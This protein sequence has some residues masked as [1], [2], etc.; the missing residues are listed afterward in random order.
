MYH[1]YVLFAMT[2]IYGIDG[3]K[4]VVALIGCILSIKLNVSNPSSLYYLYVVFIISS[5]FQQFK[6]DFLYYLYLTICP[7]YYG[8]KISTVI[9]INLVLE[10]YSLSMSHKD[11]HVSRD[12]YTLPYLFILK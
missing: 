3:Q 9:I 7:D 1:Y 12:L 8:M 4:K 6:Y 10:N 5:I 2:N 11:M